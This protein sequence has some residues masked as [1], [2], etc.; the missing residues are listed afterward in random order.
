MGPANDSDEASSLLSN[1]SIPGD[2]GSTENGSKDS[3]H[4]RSH[5][6]DI[7]GLALL[8]KVDFWVLF[9]MLGLLTGIGL[10]TINNIGNDVG[11][12]TFLMI[13]YLLNT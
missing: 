9:S 11:F 1:D 6:S 10:M 2:I 7:T 3:T 12:W 8:R 4:S 13:L 5:S